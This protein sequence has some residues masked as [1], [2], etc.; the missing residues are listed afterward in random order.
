MPLLISHI[1]GRDSLTMHIASELISVQ[2]FH[3]LRLSLKDNVIDNIL[4]HID[5]NYENP[6]LLHKAVAKQ[7]W[8]LLDILLQLGSDVNIVD[9]TKQTPLLFA[10]T[11]KNI[12]SEVIK[13]LCVQCS[14]I[15]LKE[16]KCGQTAL[17]KVVEAE[18]WD[19]V[20]LLVD[21]GADLNITDMKG[22]AAVHYAVH[23][24]KA[25][26]KIQVSK[27]DLAE[28]SETAQP[29]VEDAVLEESETDEDV[30]LDQI[31]ESEEQVTETNSDETET[32]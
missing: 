25:P 18:R 9:N 6:G 1:A 23:S 30:S 20:S 13:R 11:F 12:P 10:C 22:I 15:N 8:E 21:K 7:K 24:R 27:E 2:S 4:H 31:S 19:L 26:E 14:K 17:H 32:N 29:T 3:K 5:E 28:L 16:L